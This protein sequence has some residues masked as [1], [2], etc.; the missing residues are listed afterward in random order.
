M[1]GE[2]EIKGSTLV[3]QTIGQ[4]KIERIKI[5]SLPM[6]GTAIGARPAISAASMSASSR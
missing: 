5:S 6:R 1:S 2:Q 3:R 4:E